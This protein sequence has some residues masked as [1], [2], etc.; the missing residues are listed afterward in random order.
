MNL[1]LKQKLLAG[2]ALNCLLTV[3]SSVCIMVQVQHMRAV[4][5]Q[6]NKVPS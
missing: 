2:F 6:I 3:A 4:E 5:K 1:S